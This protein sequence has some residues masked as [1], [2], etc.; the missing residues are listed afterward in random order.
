VL[1]LDCWGSEFC[2]SR[3][4]VSSPP[5]LA[6]PPVDDDVLPEGGRLG[7]GR[8][9]S[10]A[11]CLK[12]PFVEDRPRRP[13]RVGSATIGEVPSDEA[14]VLDPLLAKSPRA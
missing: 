2:L 13:S 12:E 3:D 10:S 4:K 8:G 5:R 11:D 7:V 14:N 9:N 6:L 1:C